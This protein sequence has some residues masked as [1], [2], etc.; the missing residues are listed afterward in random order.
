MRILDKIIAVCTLTIVSFI[1]YAQNDTSLLWEVTGI[2]LEQPSYIFG[3]IHMI[4]EDDYVMTNV[5]Q[6][7]LENADAFYAE[8]DFSNAENIAVMQQ[9]MMSE[10]P[11]SQRINSEQYQ[12]LKRLLDEVVDLDI[13]QLENLTDAAIVSLVTFKSFPCTDFKMYEL[14]LLQTATATDKKTGGLETA[15]EQMELLGKTVGINTVFEMLTDLKNDGFKTTKEMVELY[16]KQDVQGLYNYMKKSSY[17]TDEVYNQM[18]T[19]RNHNW[20]STMHDLMLN[21]SVFF[22]VGAGHLKGANGLIQLLKAHGY[23]VKPVNIFEKH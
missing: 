18:L 15:A 8:I 11:L 2:N 17:M 23:N 13:A 4:C 19:K 22:A 6:N 16:T 1:N 20:I 21:Q 3:T 10:T 9:S 12:T 7:K 14:E 5:I